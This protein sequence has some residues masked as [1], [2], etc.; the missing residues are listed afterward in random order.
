[1][2]GDTVMNAHAFAE[3]LKLLRKSHNY[4]QVDVA[5]AIGIARQTYSNYET[6]KRTLNADLS[7]R[8]AEFYHISIA[9]LLSPAITGET[10]DCYQDHSVFVDAVN[11]DAYMKFIERESNP[12]RRS[13]LDYY[14]LQLLFYYEQLER[15][16]REEI[17]E[18]ARMKYRRQ[19]CTQNKK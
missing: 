17:I 5:E 4:N 6:G 2:K 3:K 16:D 13:V 12:R 1:M 7:I 19:S 10:A 9:E 14:E 8:I 18:I 11:M 15:L